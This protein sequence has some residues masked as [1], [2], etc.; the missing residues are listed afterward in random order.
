MRTTDAEHLDVI[1]VGAGLSGVGAGCRLRRSHPERSFAL[2]EGRDALGGT[3]DLFRYP[4]IRSDSDMHTLGYD[5]APWTDPQSIADGP[6]ILDYV[7]RTADQYH[8]TERIR[9]GHRVTAASWSDAE[10]RWTVHVERAD[11]E[12]LD[13]T[14]SFLQA[15]TGYYDYEGGYTPEFPGAQDFAGTIIHPQHWPEDLDYAGKRVVV[16]GSGA[17]AITLLP[18]MAPTAAHVTMLQRSP[19]YVVSQPREDP[20]GPYVRRWLPAKPAYHVIRAKNVAM[21]ILSYQLSRRAPSVMKK[22]L[23]KG[24]LA[25]LPAGFDVDRHFAPAY[26]PWDQRLCVAPDGDLFAAVR[27]GKASIVTDQIETFTERGIRLRSGDELEADIIITATG[28]KV[29]AFGAI[30]VDVNGVP[31]V[32]PD[33][34]AYKAM[35][36]SGIPNFAFVIGYTNAS[37]TLKADL[38]SEYVSRMLT[39]MDEHGYRVVRP[40]AHPDGVER[41]PLMDLTSGYIQRAL[42]QL[43]GQGSVAPWRMHQNYVLDRF[44]F[45]RHSVN[46]GVLEFSAGGATSPGPPAQTATAA[47]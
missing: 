40:P 34:L 16:I 35:M 18:S 47:A 25:Q 21:Q 4:G 37:W 44:E 14:C 12:E 23:R 27:S 45:T 5:F 39:F 42:G 7:R 28:L 22:L 26:D 3:W 6:K 41:Q 11:G 17:T 30:D 38:V 36:L 8:V 43:P 46:D 33:L 9:F 29:K 19:S 10:C 32:V 13:L 1:V 31:V 20:I 24:A 15:C 2:L